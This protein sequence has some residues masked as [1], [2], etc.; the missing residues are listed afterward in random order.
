MNNGSL[1]SLQLLWLGLAH[2]KQFQSFVSERDCSTF[3]SRSNGEGL[4]FLTST[5]PN[6]GR[7]LDRFH[8]T[9]AWNRVEGFKSSSTGIPLFLGKAI[10][11]ALAGQSSAVDCVRQLS[12]MFYKLEVE[13]SS[14][15]VEEYLASF[16]EVDASLPSY[17]E[18]EVNP[19]VQ[20]ARSLIY[21]VLCNTNPMD[22]RPRHGSGATACRT[23]NRDK[24]EKL[25]YYAQLDAHYPYPEYFFFSATHLADEL[26]KLHEAEVLEPSARVVLVP[27]DSRGPRII[28]C[29]PAELMYIQQGLMEVL[30]ETI[31]NHPLTA[32]RVNFTDQSLNR[33]MALFG[34]ITDQIATIDLKDASDRVSLALVELLFPFNWVEAFKACR[35][36]QT[37]LPDGSK[38][39]LQKFAPMGSACCFPVEALTFWAIASAVTRDLNTLVYGDDIICEAPQADQVMDALESFGLKVNR[40]KSYTTGPFRESCGGDYHNGCDVT[41]VRV[42]KALGTS[43]T[44]RFTATDLANELLAKFG[45]EA[46]GAIRVIEDVIGPIPRSALPIPGTLRL[47]HNSSNDALF[48]RRY[49]RHLQRYEHRILQPSVRPVKVREPAWS[50]LLRK[51]LQRRSECRPEMDKEN[52]WRKPTVALEPGQY[53]DPYSTRSKWGW[54][55][56]GEP[57]LGGIG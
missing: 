14:D 53:V 12:Y 24:Y 11:L 25:R 51:E 50:E 37:T 44:L 45:L 55:W 54:V 33:S 16:K 10:E 2:T 26:D 28:S 43:H 18:L 17:S 38:V 9:G 39:K 35:S 5:L 13:F 31:E 46:L 3:L 21:R 47:P 32:G 23:S 42:R 52:H 57:D 27:K 36:P 30:Y 6:I 56:L 7:E 40:D 19:L 41:P 49:N 15:L 29:E 4:A 34:S 22:I 48:Q 20:E 8:A 1:K